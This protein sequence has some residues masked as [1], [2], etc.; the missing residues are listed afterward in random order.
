MIS[1]TANEKNCGSFFIKN[2]LVLR[3]VEHFFGLHNDFR[4]SG[5]VFEKY[6]VLGNRADSGGLGA[7]GLKLDLD[8]AGGPFSF[9]RLP[10]ISFLWSLKFQSHF[11]KRHQRGPLDPRQRR[12][13][14]S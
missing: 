11:I 10:V 5:S 3:F 4:S 14:S 7:D 8:P 1:E 12:G 9:N 6:P 13:K 2:L